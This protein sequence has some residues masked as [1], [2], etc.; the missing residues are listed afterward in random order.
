MKI[1]F[2]VH[3]AYAIGGTVRSTLNLAGA[4]AARHEVEVVSVFRTEEK[5][6]LGVSGKVR[7][8]PL[9]DERPDAP[10]FDGGHPLA[11][12]P[13][14]L[15]PP[16][17]VLAHRYSA[18]SDERLRGF[19]DGTDADVLVAT[20]PALVV[21]LAE[22]GPARPLRIGQEHLSYDNHVPGVRAAQDDA[23]GRLDAFVTVSAQDAA[24]H[25]AHLPGLRTR[26]TDIPNAAPRPKAARSDL[27]APLVVAAG[28]LMPVKRY[29]LLIDAFAEVVAVRPEWRLRIYGQGPERAAL[30]AAVDA[31]RLNDRI[32]LMGPHTTMETEWAKASVA[33]VSSDWESFG[34]TILE[35]M[36]AGVPVV[37]T[38]CPHGPGEII[39][40]GHDGLLVEPGDP[41]ALAA[42]LLRLIEDADRRR[43]M[44]ESARATA[45]RFS[46]QRIA[47]EYE[48]LIAEL[49]EDRTS[50]AAKARRRVRRMFGTLLPT[51]APSPGASAAHP[52]AAPVPAD[53]PSDPSRP[54]GPPRPLR[55]K[56]RCTTD[57]TGGIRV[58]VNPSGVSG[59]ALALLLRR[60]HGDDEVR[61]PLRPPSDPKSPWTA[62]LTHRQLTL[63][64]GRW[65]LHVERAADGALRRITAG[66]VEQRGLLSAEPAAGEAFAWWIPYA[67][68]DR[69]LALRAFRRPA[70]AE[71]TALHT[72]DDSLSVHGVFYG[73]T[74][75]RGAA[76]TGV[77]RDGTAYDFEAPAV[78][79]GGRT[80]R[81]R[82]TSLPRPEGVEKS[83][84]DLFVRPA[85]AADPIRVGRIV[86]D[87][88]DRKGTDRHPATPLGTGAAADRPV[89]ARFFF[90]VTNDLAISAT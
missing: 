46:P 66:L 51:R 32:L 8:V 55:P 10:A 34:M 87:I 79:D 3:N 74:L 6:L 35:A 84:W 1:T 38:D 48:R 14:A 64:E 7:L 19:L 88:V 77:S 54:Q 45:Q 9:V 80:F 53:R 70:H 58:A 85:T 23:I 17:E 20:R 12:R 59:D 83:L 18:L 11:A 43:S 67:T 36:H 71:A 62:E 90:T 65:D 4:L 60:R 81:A 42:G 37:A 5:P 16:T 56:G 26:I 24:D 25:R 76:L 33:A 2:L 75:G 41:K 57:S 72:D 31:H 22:H 27:A 13:S 30:R 69:F 68:K 49:R 39:T 50:T 61:V 29:D 40:H 73:A 52:P 82:I 63:G 89:R 44:G 47:A 78:S 28:R 21:L 15:V 86:D